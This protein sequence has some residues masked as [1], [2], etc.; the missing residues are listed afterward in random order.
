MK[1]YKKY[2]ITLSKDVG[3]WNLVELFDMIDY[4]GVAPQDE[5]VF[6]NTCLLEDHQPL[7]CMLSVDKWSKDSFPKHC[8]SL[9]DS[10]LS[11][12]LSYW[13]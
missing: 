2:K 13:R 8:T 6:A 12:I 9:S 4:G 1:K 3:Q 7:L 10:M 11:W 5:K